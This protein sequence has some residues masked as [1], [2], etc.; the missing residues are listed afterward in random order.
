MFS[1]IF[2]NNLLTKLIIKFQKNWE[3]VMRDC[4]VALDL[5]ARYT[6]ALVRRAKSCEILQ[7]LEQALEDLTAVCIME[8]FQNQSTLVNVDRVLKDLGILSFS[9]AFLGRHE[10]KRSERSIVVTL[11]YTVHSFQ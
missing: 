4:T 10:E 8:S 1:N 11:S 2:R 3:N 6:K 7:D 9:Y 5:N